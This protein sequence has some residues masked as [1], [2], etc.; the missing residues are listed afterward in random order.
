M[1]FFLVFIALFAV[2]Y[3][4]AIPDE[5]VAVAEAADDEQGE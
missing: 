1:R 2:A 4:A 3:S 5:S